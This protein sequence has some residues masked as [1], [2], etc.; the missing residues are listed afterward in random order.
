MGRSSPKSRSIIE[1]LAYTERRLPP[2]QW[3]QKERAAPELWLSEIIA[4]TGLLLVIFLIART[5]RSMVTPAVG[6]YIGAAGVLLK[7]SGA[8]G[9]G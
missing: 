6:A 5:R 3:S 8:Q 9:K 1:G 4:T 7:L 2:A